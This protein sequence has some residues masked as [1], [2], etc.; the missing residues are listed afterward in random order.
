MFEKVL[1]PTD[2]SRYSSKIIECIAE[3]PGMKEVVLLHVLDASNPMLLEKSGWSYDTVI[4]EATTRL[5]EQVEQIGGIACT[6]ESSFLQV[7]AVLKVIVEPM[8]GA[9]G[10]NLKRLEPRS[11]VSLVYGGDVGE[12]ILKTA[13]E[14]NVSL[15]I[16]G[17]QGKGF[18]EGILLGSVSTEVLRQ[19]ETDLL[20]IRHRIFEAGGEVNIEKFCP[21]IFSKIL[22]TTD[23]SPAAEEAI[24]LV[25]GLQGI[26]EVLLVHVISKEEEFDLAAEK[27]NMTRQDIE[28]TGIMVTVHVL[29]G[30]PVDQILNLA[31]KQDASLVILSSQGKGWIRQMRL[32]STSFDVAR[33]SDRPVLVVRQNK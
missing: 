20:I 30:N 10:V 32:G 31:K 3:I 18:L 17:A 26:R 27:L 9:D 12:A 25:K 7:K 5:N 6:K 29:K 11:D 15:V 23:L 21:N 28:L 4:S 8:S 22:V 33:R 1:I 16:M 2:F 24:S 13:T 19:G 14:E